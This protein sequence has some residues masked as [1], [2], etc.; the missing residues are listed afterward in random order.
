V[1]IGNS[2]DAIGNQTRDL[3]VCSAVPQGN[4][5]VTIVIWGR[6]TLKGPSG[7]PHFICE[8]CSLTTYQIASEFVTQ[9]GLLG[10]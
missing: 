4:D 8:T 5:P 7:S 2:S 6:W 9:V 3:P 1:L 10:T